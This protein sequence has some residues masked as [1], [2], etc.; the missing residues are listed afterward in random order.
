MYKVKK[1]Y[2]LISSLTKSP[3]Y[4]LTKIVWLQLQKTTWSN[5]NFDL[6]WLFTF[7]VPITQVTHPTM[8]INLS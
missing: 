7:V 6:V 3:F 4:C 8:I 2:I 1:N 5:I